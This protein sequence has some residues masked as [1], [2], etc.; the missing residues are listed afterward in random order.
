MNT[1]FP[2]RSCRS[3][4]ATSSAFAASSRSG[5]GSVWRRIS[6]RWSARACNAG[7]A[8][9]GWRSFDAYLDR[10]CEPEQDHERQHLIDLLTTNETYFY[11]EPAHF[12]YLLE[13]ILPAYRGRALRVWSAACSSGEEVYTLAMVLAEGLGQGDW[14][15]LGTDISSRVLERA[16]LGLYPVD[17]AKRLP[18]PWLGKYCLKGVRSQAGNLLVD[19]RL[20]ARVRLEPHNLM[21]P[22]ARGD[23]FDIVFLRNVLIYFDPPTKQRVIDAISRSIVPGGLLFISHVESLHGIDTELAMVRPS[24]FSKPLG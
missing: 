2:S 1:S 22:L 11:R 19:P 17:R 6:A 4:T 9:W 10:V 3:W 24:V 16:R 14:S 15:I 20:K 8:T 13:R 7:C 21:R 18:K 23:A 5:R 12:D